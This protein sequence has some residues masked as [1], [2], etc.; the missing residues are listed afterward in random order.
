MK[1]GIFVCHCGTNIASTVDVEEVARA[2]SSLPKVKYA[3]TYKYMC[4]APGQALIKEMI[5]EKG[6]DRIVV[7][8]CSPGLHEKTFRKCL[9][10]A[11]IN[12][13]LVE[14]ANIREHCSWVHR[15]REKATIEPKVTGIIVAVKKGTRMA[16]N[17]TLRTISKGLRLCI[18]KC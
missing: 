3:G 12:P 15:D 2:V 18:C 9:E 4:S 8:A 16:F 1:I 10:E 7:C 14:I 6:L 13:Y 11:G 17:Q 5:H